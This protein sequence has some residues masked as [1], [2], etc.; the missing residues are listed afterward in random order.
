MTRQR[1]SASSILDSTLLLTDFSSV[2]GTA[3]APIPS[4]I[5]SPS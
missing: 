1:L 2:T 3:G 4:F 5:A